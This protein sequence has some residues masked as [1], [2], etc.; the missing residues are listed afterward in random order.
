[1]DTRH[2]GRLFALLA[3]LLVW[4]AVTRR[5]NSV[6]RMGIAMSKIYMPAGHSTT[7]ASRTDHKATVSCIF[8]PQGCR[9]SFRLRTTCIAD[10]ADE[11]SMSMCSMHAIGFMMLG[12]SSYGQHMPSMYQLWCS[13]NLAPEANF[14]CNLETVQ[15]HH[16]SLQ[17]SL[18]SGVQ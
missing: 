9:T 3:L 12:T 18:T 15:W 8:L 11:A 14:C 7:G 13:C 2:T 5:L 6:L 4:Q 16:S 10:A 1:M 17:D